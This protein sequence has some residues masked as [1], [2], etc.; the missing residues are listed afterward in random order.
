MAILV[1][2]L[3]NIYSMC[4]MKMKEINDWYDI[5]IFFQEL[6]KRF[7]SVTFNLG[8]CILLYKL[9]CSALTSDTI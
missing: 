8:Q 1:Y 6:M 4:H 5:N 7:L 2:I 9:L 3:F